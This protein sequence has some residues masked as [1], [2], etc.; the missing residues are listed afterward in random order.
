MSDPRPMLE[1]AFHVR[2]EPVREDWRASMQRLLAFGY[3]A[4]CVFGLILMGV[5]M[6]MQV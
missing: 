5:I 2:A 1:Y 3:V 6:A 4:A